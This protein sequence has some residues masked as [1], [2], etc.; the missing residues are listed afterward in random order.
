MFLISQEVCLAIS[1][2]VFMSPTL[3]IKETPVALIFFYK[4]YFL[5]LSESSLS[6]SCILFSISV[7]NTTDFQFNANKNKHYLA[8]EVIKSLVSSKQTIFQSW[9]ENVVGIC[10]RYHSLKIYWVTKLAL[11]SQR[12]KISRAFAKSPSENSLK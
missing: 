10:C 4:F 1:L 6:S 8:E 3:L 11:H 12:F 2:K 9:W 7:L 5:V